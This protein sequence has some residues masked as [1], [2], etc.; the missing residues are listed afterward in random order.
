MKKYVIGIDFG[1]LS[2]RAVIAD[3]E[4]GNEVASATYEYPHGVMDE[5]LPCG[6]ELPKMWALQHPLDY[7]EALKI[8]CHKR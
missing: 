7:I 4:N 1:T 6:K 5:K 3:P 2:A 8:L